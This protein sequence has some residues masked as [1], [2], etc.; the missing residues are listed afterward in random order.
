VLGGLGNGLLLGYLMY[1]SNLVQRRLALLGLIDG[2]L[3]SASGL[4]MLLGFYEQRSVPA[5]IATI[6]EFFWELSCRERRC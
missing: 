3:V 2:P 4:L 5:A 1:R 6:P